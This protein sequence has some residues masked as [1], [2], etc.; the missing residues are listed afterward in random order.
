MTEEIGT[1]SECGMSVL[2]GELAIIMDD[3]SSSEVVHVFCPPLPKKLIH[4][5][6]V[7][8][9][10]E[11]IERRQEGMEEPTLSE[12]WALRKAESKEQERQFL[13]MVE[14][15]L[16]ER[17]RRWEG[18][19]QP[20][21]SIDQIRAQMIEKK[22]GLVQRQDE[23][24]RKFKLKEMNRR[25]RVEE[26][27]DRMAPKLTKSELKSRKTKEKERQREWDKAWIERLKKTQLKK[28]K[29][30]YW[31]KRNLDGVIQFRKLR[32]KRLKEIKEDLQQVRSGKWPSP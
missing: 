25:E 12:Y 28:K 2:S 7:T 23:R 4:K 3:N 1:C 24:D 16:I 26:R 8:D 11:V 18:E 17:K 31:H 29:W 20:W 15:V 14:E 10:A 32:E 9:F 27:L 5:M 6:Y 13:K 30:D 22:K 21:P 19:A